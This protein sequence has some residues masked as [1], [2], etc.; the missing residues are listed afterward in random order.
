MD[1]SKSL[2]VLPE[3][4]KFSQVMQVDWRAGQLQLQTHVPQGVL[5]FIIR[6]IDCNLLFQTLHETIIPQMAI[7]LWEVIQQVCTMLLIRMDPLLQT[8]HEVIILLLGSRHFLQTQQQYTILQ[9]VLG[10]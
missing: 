9:S 10:L 1:K 7:L 3:L 4:E 6:V 2:V 5:V 8:L